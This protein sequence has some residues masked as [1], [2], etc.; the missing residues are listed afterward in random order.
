[1]QQELK[2]EMS[3]VSINL[4]DVQKELF[5][6]GDFDFITFQDGKEHKK[7]KEALKLLT[8]DNTREFLYGGAAGSAKSYTGAVWLIYSCLLYPGINTFVGRE[9]LKS[10][11]QS[12]KKTIEKAIE[13]LNI[14][15]ELFK[16]DGQDNVFEFYNGSRIELIDL[17][18]KPSSSYEARYG[19]IEYTFGWIEEAQGVKFEAYDTL[20]TRVG[21]HLNDK[22]GL[23]PKIFTT[24]NPSKNWLYSYFY[25]PSKDGKLPK[26]TYFLSALPADNPFLDSDYIEQ[27]KAITDKGKRERLLHGNWEYDDSPYK[28]C[29]YE[30]IT[31]IFTNSHTVTKQHKYYITADVARFGSD[32]AVIGVW[33]NWEL[34]Q[35]I[36][37]EKSKTTEI[38]SA[39][40]AA[41][42]RYRIPANRVIV[43]SDGIGSGVADQLNCIGFVNNARPFKEDLGNRKDKPRYYN[44]QTQMLVYLAEEII[45]KNELYISAEL[46]EKQKETIKL[47]L[48]TIERIPDT[49]PIRLVPKVQIKEDIGHSPDYRDM[50][51]MRCYFD[52]K[53]VGMSASEVANVI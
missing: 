3:N 13:N 16:Y 39:I 17:S 40:K 42:S 50:V 12:T 41:Q 11:R 30:R 28:L 1:M 51:F 31:E 14:P 9:T 8:D 18:Y 37:F 23:K 2:K 10:L 36:T 7:Q 5:K 47:E 44:L 46:S 29:L 34:I 33:R 48:D 38:T 20:R 15:T 26:E 52:F 53:G 24:C 4:V 45:N 32:L 22:Y 21:R 25:K 19:S 27:L 49:D 43:D 6:R 35:V